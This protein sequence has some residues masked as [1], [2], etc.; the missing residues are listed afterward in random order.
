MNPMVPLL[1]PL[2]AGWAEL[3]GWKKCFPA[4][5][6]AGGVGQRC[7]QTVLEDAW[8][9]VGQNTKHSLCT[10]ERLPLP[11]KNIGCESL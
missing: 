7:V 4:W 10:C 9:S 5:R 8:C 2:C 3:C 6:G 1:E 11:V